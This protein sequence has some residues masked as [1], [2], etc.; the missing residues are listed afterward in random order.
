[1]PRLKLGEGY[2]LEGK[3]F[4]WCLITVTEGKSTKTGEPTKSERRHYFPKLTQIAAF[5]IAEEAKL[6]TDAKGLVDAI[7][8]STQEITERLLGVEERLSREGNDVKI[9][10]TANGEDDGAGTSDEKKE[11]PAKTATTRRR[12]RKKKTA[13]SKS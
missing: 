5:L 2:Y 8:N 3:Q 7:N 6:A 12:T 11:K 9:E 1:M 10:S 4:D 13:S